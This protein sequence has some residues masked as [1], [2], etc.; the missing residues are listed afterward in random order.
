MAAVAAP[1]TRPVESGE[2]VALRD[3]STVHVRAIRQADEPEMQRFFKSLSIESLAFRFFTAG[4]SD[5]GAAHHAVDVDFDRSYALVALH[6]PE[7]QIVG[8]AMYAAATL[9]SVEVAFVL[10]E[11]MQGRGLGTVL[12]AHIAEAAAARGFETMEAEVL[13][14][15]SR[16][17]EVIRES[18]FPFEFEPIPGA[19]RAR[20]P[21]SM[22]PEAIRR[23]E[24]RD[25]VAA[26][27]AVSK[28][29]RPR[30]VA[31]VGASRSRNHVG[32]AI[33]HNLVE[34]GF[35]GTVYPVNPNAES[36]QGVLAFPSIAALP[37][38]P[39]L[40]VIATP[41]KAVIETA[42]DCA[43][44]GV[45]ALVVVSAGFAESGTRGRARQ[46]ELL[47]ICRASGM[48]LLG[49]NCLGVISTAGDVR[50][51]AT[52]SRRMPP[53]GPLALGSQSGA[54]GLAA[55]D[56]AGSRG[57]GLAAFVSLGNNADLSPNEMLDY[58]EDDPEVG[59]V[60][61]YL[62]SIS[63][64]RGFSRIARRVSRAKPIVVVKSGRSRAGSGAIASHTGA[65]LAASDLTVDAL[66]EQSGVIRAETL[67]D[68]LDVAALLGT[69]PLPKGRRVAVVTNSGGPGILCADA[70]A[71]EGLELAELSKSLQR[72]LRSL[73]KAGASTSNPVDMLATAGPEQYRRVMR[74][75][76][77]DG[78]VDAMVAIYTPTGLEDPAEML[79]GVA[80]GVD[81]V[82]GKIP[83]LLVALT[84][85]ASRG[86]VEGRHG[87]APVYPFPDDAARALGHAMR[88]HAWLGRTTGDVRVFADA[89]PERAATVI[90]ESLAHGGGWLAA[91]A[92][93]DLLGAYG[94]RSIDHR[95]VAS[96][97]EA[98]EAA[99][100]L[101]CPVA[102]KGDA[103]G[104][105]H[106]TEAGA[107]ALGLASP[108]DVADAA[109]E[110]ATRLATAGT[111]VSRFVV[112]RMA[113]DGI[114]MLVGVVH[115]P[116]LGPVLVCGAGGVTAEVVKDLGARLTPVTDVEASELVSSLHIAPLLHGWRGSPPADVAALEE[117]LLRISALVEGHPEVQELDLNPVV[118]NGEGAWIV[119]ARVLI[120]AVADRRPWPSLGADGPPS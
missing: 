85:D 87:T 100:S 34:G 12:L 17:L 73:L 40:A 9:D 11:E 33:F 63:N 92:V 31:L 101:G 1:A 19:V 72:K 107:V 115:D 5:A 81:A 103:A 24:E 56:R 116:S 93:A 83:L 25:H 29:L 54:L 55:I 38:V 44:A 86:L 46:E 75:I 48:R 82:A 67:A 4:I 102:L 66:F 70:L 114:E 30:A 98:A 27:A 76:A 2:D 94:L 47:D 18:G 20:S 80:A 53:A 3:G 95:I 26:V 109:E 49:P 43:E 45:P 62:E 69:Q 41:A 112:Q 104:V 99:R 35:A 13:P 96:P 110:M 65:V 14:S 37:A 10:S 74:T 118:V 59:V 42:R 97:A 71:A 32:G 50:L 111:P 36:V 113:R 61:L 7:Q 120:A 28:I 60:A 88:R 52:F 68:L 90:A 77:D 79:R 78:S 64:P 16:M 108:A 57:I 23:F 8:H 15:N 39:D 21:V 89:R 119:D 105:L 91:D 6:G 106:K 84:R 58:W 22:T 117:T 51:N